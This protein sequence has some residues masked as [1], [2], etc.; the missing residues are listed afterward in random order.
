MPSKASRSPKNKPV[1]IDA[2]WEFSDPE[3]SEGVFSSLLPGANPSEKLELLTQIARTHSLRGQ[4]AEAQ[5]VL[6]EVKPQLAGAG[7]KPAVRYN[8][9]QG[10]VFN[11][12][13]EPAK[14]RPFFESAFEQA[15]QAGEEGLAVDAA[16]MVAITC[17][18]SQEGIDWNRKAL[19]IAQDSTDPKA[20]GLRAAICNN[21][22][23]DLFDS[24]QVEAALPVFLEAQAAWSERGRLAQI[25]IARWSVARCLRALKRCPE[26]ISILAELEQE[27]Q[28]AGTPDGFVFEELAENYD[29]IGESAQARHY[30]ALA[31]D[32][33]AKDDW[34]VQHEPAR[35]TRLQARANR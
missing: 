5:A 35:L 3:K 21:M 9:E 6:D 2:Y 32:E 28:S 13:G 25:R 12:N 7:I 8:L 10:R 26:A 4:F 15:R 31:A 11:S 23:W 34:F 19:D 33:L 17:S 24:G 1:N 20:V 22:A 14:A 16:H 29:A 30:F 27:H 18:G